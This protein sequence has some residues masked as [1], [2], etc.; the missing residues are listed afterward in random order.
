MQP[1][2]NES[3]T[4]FASNS[5]SA[6]Y[7]SVNI[8]VGKRENP[9]IEEAPTITE[10]SVAP[11]SIQQGE[12]AVLHWEV[13][14]S[15]V[16]V[17]IDQGIGEVGSTGNQNIAPLVTTCYTISA[18][19]EAGSVTKAVELVVSKNDVPIM[20][21]PKLDFTVEPEVV[22]FG[23][24]VLVTW[25]TDG[26]Q[27]IIDQG[28]GVRGPVGNEEI[29]FQNPGLKKFTAVAYGI[30]LS[31][32]LKTDS[33]L[34]REPSAPV[35]P[36][37]F[38]SVTDSVEI[39]QPAQIEWHSQK[40][41]RVEIDFV[42]SPSLNGKSEVIFYSL[43]SREITATA[44]NQ[45]GQVS[46]IE[47]INV[48]DVTVDPQVAPIFIPSMAK[49]AAYHDRDKQ[50]VLNAGQGEISQAGWYQVS[51]S[52]W[53]NSGDD[54]TNE[55]FYIVIKTAEGNYRYPRDANAGLYKV[56]P[57][58]P[59]APHV[60]EREAGL[61]YLHS[62]SFTI[63][64]HHYVT[65]AQDYPQFINGGEIAGPESVQVISFMLNYVQP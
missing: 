41:D 54:Q 50:V 49:V 43:G 18:S 47:I 12:T 4:L 7:Q 45:A 13:S 51:A 9:P 40:A 1:T 63:E 6:V 37:I 60:K 64:L 56:V 25:N 35:L 26:F 44:Y 16:K 65:I 3:Y 17:L 30:D 2:A 10:F 22:E 15:N 20:K 11:D 28:I 31:T 61:F 52:V 55:S 8:K 5:D 57:D 42:P 34:I 39:G 59:G 53:Y 46:V 48:V 38:L 58:D 23:E 19:N 14:G 36:L 24:P 27:V 62:G 29:Y 21:F 32:T 33:V